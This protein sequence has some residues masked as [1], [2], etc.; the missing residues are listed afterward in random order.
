[1]AKSEFLNGYAA[2][3]T[4]IKDHDGPFEE[5][6]YCLGRDGRR[7]LL[8]LEEK[9]NSTIAA[10]VREAVERIERDVARTTT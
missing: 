8:R 4:A 2:C 3:L 10:K 7:A 6:V 9:A 1:M 5:A